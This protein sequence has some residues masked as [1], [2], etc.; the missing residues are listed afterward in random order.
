VLVSYEF[1]TPKET[2]P[3]DVA[4]IGVTANLLEQQLGQDVTHMT[5]IGEKV[6]VVDDAQNFEGSR[7]GNWV[8]LVRVAV[9]ERSNSDG[10]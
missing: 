8:T 6:V 3:T 9:D 10:G 7:A 5:H 4:N 2:A 1:N